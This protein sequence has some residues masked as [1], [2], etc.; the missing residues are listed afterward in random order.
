M[1]KEQKTRAQSVFLREFA[2][3][4]DGSGIN[5]P[6][7]V[8]LQRWMRSRRFVRTLRQAQEAQ[9]MR[10]DAALTFSATAA[11]DRM[12]EH[13]TVDQPTKKGEVLN[14]ARNLSALTN[15]VK[16]SHKRQIDIPN[17]PEP[18]YERAAIIRLLQSLHPNVRVHDVRKMLEEEGVHF[19]PDSRMRDVYD[20][21][22]D[23]K[24]R[25]EIERAEVEKKKE[26]NTY[27]AKI[28]TGQIKI[29]GPNG[30]PGID[31]AAR[32]ARIPKP[33]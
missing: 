17:P 11:A 5:W 13:V 12:R 22:L 29:T 32:E 8:I 6:S 1:R 24:E 27:R 4:T 7:P 23:M 25:L 15:I 31:P 30:E 21:D 28:L 3:S 26:Y 19:R 10:M 20:E 18:D 9:R 33:E 16:V 14:R 2:Q